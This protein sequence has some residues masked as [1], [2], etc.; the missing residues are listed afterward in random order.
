MKRIKSIFN[1]YKENDCI[2]ITVN[3]PNGPKDIDGVD[4]K[5][6][7][8]L[9]VLNEH[10]VET[11]ES[12]QGGTWDNGKGHSYPEPTVCF[13]GEIQEGPRA[14][15]IAT[16]FGFKVKDLRRY[17]SVINKELVGPSWQMTFRDI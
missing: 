3:T 6:V 8:L 2:D 7:K 16:T 17:Y 12:C 5:M 11:F 15:S 14:F 4:K 9:Q 13:H 10:G 1:E